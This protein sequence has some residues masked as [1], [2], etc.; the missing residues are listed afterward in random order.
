MF[1]LVHFETRE[2]RS[3]VGNDVT[4]KT[5][6]A[7]LEENTIIGETYL[8]T[9]SSMSYT[10]VGKRARQHETVNHAAGQ[11]KLEGGASTNLL[12]GFFSQLKRSLDGTHHSVSAV[13]LNRYLAQFDFM[14]THCKRTDSDRMRTLLGQVTGRRLTYKPLSGNA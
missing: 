11:Y 8:Q 9:D 10:A 1:A 5:L 7:K 14:Y 12:E 2:V 13:H 3:T 6:A 4:G